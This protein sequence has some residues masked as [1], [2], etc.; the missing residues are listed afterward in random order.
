MD[1]ELKALNKRY[2][3]EKARLHVRYVAEREAIYGKG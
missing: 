1:R 2:E 3:A